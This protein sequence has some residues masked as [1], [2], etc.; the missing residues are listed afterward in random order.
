MKFLKEWSAKLL[1]YLLVVFVV[2]LPFNIVWHF[3]SSHAYVDGYF[4]NYLDFIL[5]GIDIIAAIIVVLAACKERLWKKKEFWVLVGLLLVVL[6]FQ[7]FSLNSDISLYF[8]L[9][10]C[11]YVLAGY[12]GAFLV[13]TRNFNRIIVISLACVAVFESLLAI[14]QFT[15][16]HA[17]GLKI[18]GESAV[19]VGMYNSSSVHLASGTFLRGYG[20]FPHPNLLGAFFALSIF[21]ILHEIL[22]L[23]NR[24]LK[25]SLILIE[26]VLFAGLVVTWSRSAL[27]ILFIIV[28][29]Y[30]FVY[31]FQKSKK[32]GLISLVIF[33]LGI[34]SL[35]FWIY[36]GNSTLAHDLRTRL[37]DQTSLSDVSVVERKELATR[38]LGDFKSHPFLGIGMGNFIPSLSENPVYNESQVRVMQPAHNYLLLTLAETGVLG[39]IFLSYIYYLLFRKLRVTLFS[40]LFIL[41]ILWLSLFDHYF[42]DLAQGSAILLILA[43]IILSSSFFSDK[44]PIIKY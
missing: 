44:I 7:I 10:L 16:G 43:P 2:A 11:L 42:W 17:L 32:L 36:K 21:I 23:H 4:V 41:L 20:T 19:Q 39:V 31:L 35:G 22:N 9:R 30:L 25:I 3:D 34:S 14:Y 5:H 27:F 12:A 28:A 8:G 15:A 37:V 29:I 38:A 6:I 40:V 26:L 13:R 1:P 33:L 24:L 18:L